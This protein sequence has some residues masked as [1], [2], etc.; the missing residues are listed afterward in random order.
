MQK[1]GATAAQKAEALNPK[2]LN[3]LY[4]LSPVRPY[5]LD[6][7]TAGPW[8]FH[9]EDGHECSRQGRTLKPPNP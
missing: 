3:T 2:P 4:S 1:T 8:R 7:R 6:P 9:A 5:S